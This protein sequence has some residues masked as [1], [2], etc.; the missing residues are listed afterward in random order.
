MRKVDI[1]ELAVWPS[2]TLKYLGL[3]E[4]ILGFC[5]LLPAG[6][7]SYLGEDYIPFLA[8]VP[9]LIALGSL[10]YVLF[11]DSEDFKPV[12]GLLLIILTWFM[13]FAIGSVPYALSGL[14]VL[15][16][17]FESVSGF[18]TTGA[19]IIPDPLGE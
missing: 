15:D 14:P 17:L 1:K 4:L 13:L 19:T 18:T 16:S 5:L 8:P 11:R 2:T 6:L 9:L 10:Q 3:V 12:N 7:A